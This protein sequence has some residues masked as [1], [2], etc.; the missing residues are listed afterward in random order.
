MVFKDT[1]IGRLILDQI[2]MEKSA[3]NKISFD[4]SKAVQ[5]AEGLAKVA[6]YQYSEKVYNS[7]QEM[8]KIASKCLIDLKS[9][10]DAAIEKNAQ[11]QKA[12]EVQGIIEDMA[13][14]GLIGEHEIH[15]KVA[16]L[17]SKTSDKLEIVKEAIKLASGGKIGNVFFNEQENPALTKTAG[18]DKNGMF[19]S[20]LS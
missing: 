5:V 3:E 7:V 4:A 16:E 1:N 2:P 19:D 15:E 11:L 17:M 18:K 6:S 12:A 8:M 9:A 13:N 20:I 14:N 10:F